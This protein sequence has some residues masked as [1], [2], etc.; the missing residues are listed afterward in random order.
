MNVLTGYIVKEILKG[1]MVALIV[2]LTLFNLF[3]FSDEL[4]ILGSGNYGLKEIFKYLALTS[5]RVLY[6]LM[7]FSALLG[8]LFVLGALGNNRELIAMRASGLSLFGIIKAIMLAGLLLS[9]FAVAVGEFIAPPAERA[10]QVLKMT[11]R[12]KQVVIQSQYGL[13]LREANKFINVRRIEDNG[14]LALI[15]IYELNGEQRLDKALFAEKAA[16]RGGDRWRLERITQSEISKRQVR[17]FSVPEEI[18]RSSIDPGLINVVVVTPDNLS[19]Y[20]L[21][22][23]IE[24]LK[25]NKQKSQSFEL[26]FWSRLINPLLTFVML[27]VAT[28]FVIGVR[29]GVSIGSRMMIGIMIGMGFNITDK[30]VGHLSLI[31]E[32]N[33]AAMAFLPSAVV[34][35]TAVYAI[36]RVQ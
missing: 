10:A 7:P 34:L 21:A 26:A 25:E 32:L 16:Y 19:L 24:F 14:D 31:Y 6:E 8:S 1:S 36:K 35:L 3:T 12:N 20:D 13:W 18:W 9:G 15:Y 17:E 30:I 33:P 5:P 29:R 11:A 22:L 23:Y 4:K 2:L 28:P 27:L